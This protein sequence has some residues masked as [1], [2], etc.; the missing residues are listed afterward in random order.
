MNH[1]LTSFCSLAVALA[2]TMNLASAAADDRVPVTLIYDDSR[3][4]A[5]HKTVMYI[6]QWDPATGEYVEDW[7]NFK[8]RPMRDDGQAGDK[9]AGDHIW[10][11]VDQV[12]PSVGQVMWWA[13]DTD[14]V[15]DNGWLG[16]LG[17]VLAEPGKPV[18]S[19]AR[20]MPEESYYTPDEFGK[21]YGFDPHTV[22]PPR[23]LEDT[24]RILFTMR[25]A[26]AKRVFLAGDFNEFAH[27]TNGRVSDLQSA[28]YPAGNNVWYRTL[29]IDAP[30]FRYKYVVEQADG[31]QQWVP[32]PRVREQDKDLNSVLRRAE[33]LDAAA[34]AAATTSKV[35][36]RQY[37][38]TLLEQVRSRE[39]SVLL[40]VRV[41]DN[42]RCLDFEKKYL[43]TPGTEE[44]LAGRT[45][46]FVNAGD[47]RTRD[48]LKELRIVRVPAL[49]LRDRAGDWQK[50]AW[51]DDLTAAEVTAFI[52][53]AAAK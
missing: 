26:D 40:Y 23:L 34:A 35:R 5:P 31:T 53:K 14:T 33:L 12:R 24:G 20:S 22:A 19:M 39:G 49:A 41:P 6:C 47:E 4:P 1:N 32:D 42:Q 27:N 46:L 3:N 52:E 21:R 9:K 17:S 48:L 25:A 11:I 43:L 28:M 51:R 7:E 18:T 44:L 15:I 30:E 45:A 16:T 36:W 13:G 37:D 38:A 10:T 29:R 8:R 2:M 50:L